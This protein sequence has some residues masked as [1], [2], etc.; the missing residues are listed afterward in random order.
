MT[1]LSLFLVS[2]LQ[3]NPPNS[4]KKKSKTLKTDNNRTTIIR[5]TLDHELVLPENLIPAASYVHIT[6]HTVTSSVTLK[7]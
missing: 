6:S 3:S 5:L 7:L 2:T 1:I 4:K